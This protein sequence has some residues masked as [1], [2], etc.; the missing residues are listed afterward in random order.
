LD[1]P[2]NRTDIRRNLHSSGGTKNSAMASSLPDFGNELMKE[3]TREKEKL[4]RFIDTQQASIAMQREYS[5]KMKKN[6]QDKEK[7]A[8][9]RAD[10]IKKEQIEKMKKLKE[11]DEI[12]KNKLRL[13][14]QDFKEHQNES[15][16]QYIE[17]LKEIRDKKEA[18]DKH[19]R[20]VA[21]A[22]YKRN[23]A[24]IASPLKSSTENSPRKH[25]AINLNF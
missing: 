4:S 14:E 11:A 25:N 3:I 7:K 2:L 9:K 1:K 6:L 22:D 24:K 8:K 21:M 19:E 5:E 17:H 10:V 20:D 12:R 18:K 16:R 13:K 23:Q 15:K